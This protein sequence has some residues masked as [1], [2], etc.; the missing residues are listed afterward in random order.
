METDILIRPATIKDLDPIYGFIC[1]LEEVNFDRTEFEDRFEANLQ[2]PFTIYLVS[3]SAENEL[4]GFISCQGNT[5]L[6]QA[7]RVFAIRELYVVRPCRGK[8]IGKA[9][10]QAV[11][12]KILGFDSDRLEVAVPGSRADLRKLFSKRGFDN[13]PL[14]LIKKL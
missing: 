6:Y 10:L 11:E 1:H 12:E 14:T 2:D 4:T 5:V 7:H 13:G 8:G 3:V 9:L